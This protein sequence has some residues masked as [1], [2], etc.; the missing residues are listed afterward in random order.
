MA[1]ATS[2]SATR[3]ISS[4][5]A[6]R[7][8]AEL[9]HWPPSGCSAISGSVWPG[10]RR[11]D[12][13]ELGHLGADYGVRQAALQQRSEVGAL[14]ESGESPVRLEIGL[15]DEVLGVVG[16]AGLANRSRVERAPVGHC[17][18]GEGGAISHHATHRTCLANRCA[19]LRCPRVRVLTR[20]LYDSFPSGNVTCR[21]AQCEADQTR[22]CRPEQLHPTGAGRGGCAAVAQ[23]RRRRE[24][25]ILVCARKTLTAG[26]LFDG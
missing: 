23:A 25:G 16:I 26:E 5:S 18:V 22:S 15:L 21:P 8:A 12:R 14:P 20:C 10:R 9:D 24:R 17:L 4:S 3:A 11:V 6:D 19:C 13:Y 7:C 1:R 2:T